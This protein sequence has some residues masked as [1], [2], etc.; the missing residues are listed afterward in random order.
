MRIIHSMDER[1][2]R[3]KAGFE[4]LIRTELPG[5]AE[6]PFSAESISEDW[7]GEIIANVREDSHGAAYAPDQ[8]SLSTH[9]SGYD[10]L[11]T[12]GQE[13]Q[14]RLTS[15][16]EGVVTGVGFELIREPHI[17]LATDPTLPRGSIRVVAWH[18]SDPLQFKPAM[19][20]AEEA[21]HAEQPPSGAFFIIDGYRHFPLDK[22]V[23]NIG[24]RLDNHLILEDPRVSR[25]HAQLRVRG[26]R[27]AIL[28][29][30][31][32]A[33]TLV[34]GQPVSEWILRPG[35]VV[36]LATVQLIYG[37]DPG[38]PPQITP[39]YAPPFEPGADRDQVTPL[40]LRSV[41]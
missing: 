3:L 18:S 13:A 40:D 14:A 38:G 19:S 41:K 2:T 12:G 34:N 11:T 8:Y 21:D 15:G 9:P 1:V 36:K 25:K 6:K 29:L 28:D 23:I 5:I 32:T 27:Y 16:L 33:G 10:A 24:R 20:A 37:E 39:P 22:P 35:D 30:A 17:T 31:S 7:A 26:G 4:T